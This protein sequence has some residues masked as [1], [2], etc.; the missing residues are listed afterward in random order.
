MCNF[1]VCYGAIFYVSSGVFCTDVMFL[2]SDLVGSYYLYLSYDIESCVGNF[3]VCP[4]LWPMCFNC[5]EKEREFF[6]KLWR[7][8]Y[9]REVPAQVLP[10]KLL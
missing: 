3:L 5:K 8:P 9:M 1:L 6:R 2:T 4:L 7:F 10:W